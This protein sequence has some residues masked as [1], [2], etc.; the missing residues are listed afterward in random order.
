M[1]PMERIEGELSDAQ[2]R[3]AELEYLLA[4]QAKDAQQGMD[5]AKSV[6]GSELEQAKRLHAECSPEALESE[7]E[8]NA[9]LTERI[10]QLEQER[11][12]YR[13][14]E[15]M[16]INLREKMQDERDALAA[17]VARITKA[18]DSLTFGLVHDEKPKWRPSGATENAFS[19]V[20]DATASTPKESLI[21]RDM[22]C[23]RTG[24]WW[25]FERARMRPDESNILTEWE[26]VKG[27]ITRNQQAIQLR[28]E[29]RQ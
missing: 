19:E 11:D 28:A 20:M 9:K 1:T 23:M 10:A 2:K 18:A 14:A 29:G 8:A 17:H 15:E 16:Q 7:R 22:E 6:A 21:E 12:E 5:A 4:R 24:F 27:L 26:D 3:I 13:A 25:G